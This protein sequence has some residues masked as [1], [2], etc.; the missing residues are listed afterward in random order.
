MKT[1]PRLCW[2]VGALAWAAQAASTV[3]WEMSAYRDFLSGRFSEMS[4]TRDGRLLLAP[5]L[6]TLFASGQPIIWSLV[7]APDGTLYAG[8]GH[9]GR[10]FRVPPS[11]K[12][13]LLWAADQ[14]EVFALALDGKGALYAATSPDGKV[15]R[16]Q[17]EIGRA[18]V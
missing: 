16:I 11:G 8:T 14:P 1:L 6:E 7:Q 17:N 12:A 2:L 18:H 13:G 10:V 9:R 5:K 4:L 3:S 15:Y